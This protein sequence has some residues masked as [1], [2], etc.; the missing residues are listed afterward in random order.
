MRYPDMHMTVGR[1]ID[2]CPSAAGFLMEL[3]IDCARHAREHFESVVFRAGVMPQVVIRLICETAEPLPAEET[4]DWAIVP[5]NE[6]IDYLIATHHA[7]TRRQLDRLQILLE[8]AVHDE[9]CC[10]SELGAV[11]EAFGAF[12]LNL[13]EHM[14]KEEEVLFPIIR[15]LIVGKDR[16]GF[17]AGPSGFVVR[18]LSHD[19]DEAGDLLRRLRDKQL[20][21]AGRRV[22]RARRL[23]PG[24]LRP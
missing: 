21:R 3:G 13:E 8:K 14:R 2:V 23:P 17:F 10:R 12:R 15:S 11:R 6:F 24:A 16:R 7:Y 4:R 1:M 9:G 20:S 5:L 19:F 22:S 18:E